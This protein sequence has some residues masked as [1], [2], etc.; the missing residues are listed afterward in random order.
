VVPNVSIYSPTPITAGYAGGS[1]PAAYVQ[2]AFA[3]VLL[4]VVKPATPSAHAARADLVCVLRSREVQ[5]YVQMAKHH[6]P[7][8]LIAQSLLTAKLGT[9]VLLARAVHG[10]C[11]FWLPTPA[12]TL[13]RL[14]ACLLDVQD[15][16]QLLQASVNDSQ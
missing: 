16:E 3:S 14:D 7:V 15:Q 12:Q 8:W 1:A 6:A 11:V 10:M 9:R 5:V 13:P 4:V 2:M